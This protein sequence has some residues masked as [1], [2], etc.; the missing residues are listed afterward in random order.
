[1]K[2]LFIIFSLLFVAL[3]S[4]NKNDDNEPIIDPSS[5]KMLI[6]NEG[7]YTKVNSSLSAISYDNQTTNDVFKTVNKKPLGDVGQSILYSG[8]KYYIAMNNSKKVQVISAADYSLIATITIEGNNPIPQYMAELSPELIALSDLNEKGLHIINSKTNTVLKKVALPAAGSKMIVYGR[9]LFVNIGSGVVVLDIDN[10]NSSRTINVESLVSAQFALDK[11][12]N[13]WAI[14]SKTLFKINPNSETVT[15][16]EL[17]KEIS[18][19]SWGARLSIDEKRENLY[20]NAKTEDYKPQIYQMNI[21]QP[22]P[23]LL[24]T[25]NNVKALYNMEISPENEIVVCDALDYAQSGYVFTY[26]LDGTINKEYKVGII[27]Q[28]I[29]FTKYNKN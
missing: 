13:I 21:E 12:N 5:A 27:P 24:F 17:A 11:N 15:S 3:T 6:L 20:F 25:I 26:K 18:L 1:M 4:C 10:L 16:I 29:L 2:K 8:G 28:F 19:D 23:K 22:V 7:G 14:G 9:K